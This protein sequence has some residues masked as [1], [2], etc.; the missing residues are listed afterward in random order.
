M[1]VGEVGWR[2]G[3]VGICGKGWRWWGMGWGCAGWSEVGQGFSREGMV[4]GRAR[5]GRS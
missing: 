3:G 2:E 4:V 1:Y 5:R